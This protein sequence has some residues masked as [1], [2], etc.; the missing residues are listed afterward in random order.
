MEDAT[1]KYASTAAAITVA[2][3]ANPVSNPLDAASIGTG[4]GAGASTGAGAA[5]DAVA[6]AG[7]AAATDSS[8]F[9]FTV[10]RG[11]SGTDA[12]AAEG[13]VGA[14]VDPAPGSRRKRTVGRGISAMVG[15]AAGTA[16]RDV[17]FFASAGMPIMAV[18]FFAC[19][20]PMA[21][22]SRLDWSSATGLA[23]AL[24]PITPGGRLMRTVSFLDSS[25]GMIVGSAMDISSPQIFRL[26][27]T[28]PHVLLSTGFSA[29]ELPLAGRVFLHTIPH[30]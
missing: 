29:A 13:V 11:I 9:S 28:L 24:C 15:L 1:T 16:T 21:A 23:V 30:T 26:E 19:S 10:G 25:S 18:S 22:V 2:R 14:T 7:G 3:I 8:T 4:A 17:S 20:A 27:H 6:G 12:R 5:P